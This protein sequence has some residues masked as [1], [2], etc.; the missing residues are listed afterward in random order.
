MID[1]LIKINHWLFK[2]EE[3]RRAVQLIPHIEH[4]N[5]S[6]LQRI[7]HRLK[8][9]TVENKRNYDREHRFDRRTR[10]RRIL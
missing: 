5:E 9:D 6:I 8:D 2:D 10:M 3:L 1:F 7:T 4:V